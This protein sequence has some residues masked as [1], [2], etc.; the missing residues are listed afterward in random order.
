MV[1][2][3]QPATMD[4]LYEP[5]LWAHLREERQ[6]AFLMGP[7]QVGKTTT[8]RQV[9]A[10]WP[11]H[12]YW[13]WDHPGHRAILLAGPDRMADACDLATLRSQ[14]LLLILDEVHKYAGWK[15]LLKG[16]FDTWGERCRV[17]LTGSS[18]LDVFRHGGDSLMGRYFP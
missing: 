8:A 17:L 15:D 1:G 13:T 9:G 10:A 11:E 14:P 12:A 2:C 5:L 16:F 18:R 7:R 6:M 4:R 3:P